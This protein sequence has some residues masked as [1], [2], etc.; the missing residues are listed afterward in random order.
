[1]CFVA[2]A[3][4]ISF[5]NTF[6]TTIHVLMLN[7]FNRTIF[8]CWHK[9][10]NSNFRRINCWW[11]S[12]AATNNNMDA[13]HLHWFEQMGNWTC[14][15]EIGTFVSESVLRCHCKLVINIWS[16]KDGLRVELLRSE[17]YTY[18]FF[19]GL[20]WKKKN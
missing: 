2:I 10:F 9:N 17:A 7:E 19:T 18:L 5:I 13:L 1:M 6:F 12:L 16:V 8:F 15:Q 11:V 3:T 14:F 20:L 4:D